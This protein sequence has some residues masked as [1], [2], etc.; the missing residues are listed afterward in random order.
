MALKL[1][2]FYTQ[3]EYLKLTVKH[4][5]NFGVIV[6]KISSFSETLC[7][8]KLEYAGSRYGPYSEPY[9]VIV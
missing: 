2:N 7:Q 6:G 4:Y 5:V 1:I 3:N 9:G 8:L